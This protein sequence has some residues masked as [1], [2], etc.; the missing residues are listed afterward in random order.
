MAGTSLCLCVCAAGLFAEDLLQRDY[1][2]DRAVL[3]YVAA[4][5]G[6][7][8]GQVAHA[9]GSSK[10][11]AARSLERLRE[12]GLLVRGDGDAGH[13]AEGYRLAPQ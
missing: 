5:P 10:G 9:V 11:V 12:D 1:R 7:E 8:P 4:H 13:V 3:A 2:R 6:V